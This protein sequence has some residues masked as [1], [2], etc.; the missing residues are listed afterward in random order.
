MHGTE[1]SSLPQVI[2]AHK[3]FYSTL[4]AEEPVDL[5]VQD[6]LLSFVTHHLSDV[7]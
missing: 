2:R 4:V 3:D 6:N 7:D 5:T 1:V